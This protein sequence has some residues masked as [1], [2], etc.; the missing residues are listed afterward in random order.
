MATN[1]VSLEFVQG[2]TVYIDVLWESTGSPS[3]VNLQNSTITASIRKEYNTEVLASFSVEETD[4][5]NG[6][7]KLILSA[8]DSAAL[9]VRANSRITSFVFDVNVVLQDGSV[10]TPIY[11]YLKMQRQVTL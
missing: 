9:P 2:D 4:L 5:S 1:P 6:Q 8:T 11:G 3:T 10:Q 7:F